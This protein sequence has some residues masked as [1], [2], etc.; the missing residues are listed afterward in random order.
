MRQ[1]ILNYFYLVENSELSNFCFLFVLINR[2]CAEAWA[3]GGLAAEK[4]EREKW[5]S[6]DRKK[7]ED[8]IEALAMIKQQAEERKR[9]KASQEGGTCSGQQ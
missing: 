1:Y 6:R 4:E 8:S 9:Q 2:A 5:E 3:R 7:I